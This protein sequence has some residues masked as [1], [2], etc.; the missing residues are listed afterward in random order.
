[1]PPSEVARIQ[2]EEAFKAKLTRGELKNEKRN[3]AKSGFLL[4]LL[5]LA[6]LALALWIFQA[7]Q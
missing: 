3:Q 1:P 7:V 5:V 4:F 6:I 2:R